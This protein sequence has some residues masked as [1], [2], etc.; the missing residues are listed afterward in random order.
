MS[1]NTNKAQS[2]TFRPSIVQTIVV[3]LPG[4]LITLPL[5]AALLTR[6]VSPIDGGYIFLLMFGLCAFVGSPCLLRRN[7]LKLDS[8][9]ISYRGTTDLTVRSIPKNQVIDVIYEK[10]R[11]NGEGIPW[12]YIDVLGAKKEGSQQHIRINLMFYSQNDLKE[13]LKTMS[14]S[15]EV[16]SR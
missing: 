2:K 14:E 4:L 8:G 1:E 9:G 11:P 16:R 10:Y 6:E 3:S 12:S 5:V 13:I 7:F 15:F